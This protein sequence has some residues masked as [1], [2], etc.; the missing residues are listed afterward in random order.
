MI[1]D[2]FFRRRREQ[3]AAR[4]LGLALRNRFGP[5]Q[6]YRPADVYSTAAMIG[7][8]TA[9]LGMGLAWYC[10]RHDFEEATRGLPG[11]G[12][13]DSLR[14]EF[15]PFD[16][17]NPLDRAHAGDQVSAEAGTGVGDPGQAGQNGDIGDG[18][19]GSDSGSDG[20]DAG[21]GDGGGGGG[22][23]GGE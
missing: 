10:T 5:R 7:M 23:G 15:V 11:S 4:E 8:S 12:D 18:P 3:K 9:L 16:G 17:L 22:D 20:G 21:D 14:S 2:R 13:Y 19:G 6:H 1:L